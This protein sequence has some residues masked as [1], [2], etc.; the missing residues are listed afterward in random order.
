M[1]SMQISYKNAP[2]FCDAAK[3]RMMSRPYRM[4]W[5]RI[6]LATQAGQ[7]DTTMELEAAVAMWRIRAHELVGAYDMGADHRELYQVVQ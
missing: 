1:K 2:Q 7:V 3:G 4:W 5:N 6:V